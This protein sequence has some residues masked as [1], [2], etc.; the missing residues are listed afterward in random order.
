MSYCSSWV[1]VIAEFIVAAVETDER[2]IENWKQ[3]NGGGCIVIT[4]NIWE[5]EVV[6]VAVTNMH[7]KKF[8]IL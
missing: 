1:V 2:I 7:E 6:D 4:N 8:I 5:K 3:S